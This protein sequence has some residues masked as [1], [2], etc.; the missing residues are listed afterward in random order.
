VGNTVLYLYG[1]TGKMVQIGIRLG[2]RPRG[3]TGKTGP[4]CEEE[5][6]Q[7]GGRE[8][9]RNICPVS[10]IPQC[11]TEQCNHRRDRQRGTRVMSVIVAGT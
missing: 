8:R 9:E 10:V 2:K 5:E 11:S 1:R 4:H 3:C 6:T 7:V